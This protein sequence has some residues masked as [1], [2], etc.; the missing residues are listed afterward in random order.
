MQKILNLASQYPGDLHGMPLLKISTGADFTFNQSLEKFILA[1]EKLLCAGSDKRHGTKRGLSALWKTYN[2]L[3][4]PHKECRLLKGV[5]LEAC[6]EYMRLVQEKYAKGIPEKIQCW[7]NV[8]RGPYPAEFPHHHNNDSLNIVGV[9]YV[10]GDFSRGGPLNF[11]EE[12]KKGDMCE[13]YR[14]FPQAG[15]LVV[16]PA[17]IYH[18]KGLYLDPSPRISIAFDLRFRGSSQKQFID[19][20]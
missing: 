17:T 10:S 6:V 4:W 2:V 8:V 14:V 20:F 15:D 1:Q 13:I 12:D 9:Y 5:F 19:F 3:Q 18:G 16:F 11:F 7:A